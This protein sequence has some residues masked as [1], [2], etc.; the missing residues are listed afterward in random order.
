MSSFQ[1]VSMPTETVESVRS[2]GKSP[3]YGFPPAG[4]VCDLSV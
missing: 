1:I 3:K 2:S 4:T